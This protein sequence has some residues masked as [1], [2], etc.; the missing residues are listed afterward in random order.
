MIKSG[1]VALGMV[2]YSMFQLLCFELKM[3]KKLSV[4]R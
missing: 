2:S 1:A 3:E 4:L